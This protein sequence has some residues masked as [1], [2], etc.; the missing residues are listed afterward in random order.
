MTATL[1]ES[2]GDGTYHLAE[3]ERAGR[4]TTITLHLKPSAPEQGVEDFTDPWT[5]SR[6]V[7]CYSDFIAYPIKG[8]HR[9]SASPAYA[10]NNHIRQGGL[11]HECA[12][13]R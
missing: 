12:R 8:R 6:I 5:L 11:V 3:A 7:G 4:G 9:L 10:D 13:P 1:W 2:S